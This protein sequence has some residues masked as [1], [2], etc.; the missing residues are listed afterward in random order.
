MIVYDELAKFTEAQLQFLSDRRQRVALS[1]MK[2]GNPF[3]EVGFTP[4]QLIGETAW[5]KIPNTDPRNS[6]RPVHLMDRTQIRRLRERLDEAEKSIEAM[7]EEARRLAREKAKAEHEQALA[8]KQ[9]ALSTVG[10]RVLFNG[11]PGTIITGAAARAFDPARF[12]GDG[13]TY[14]SAYVL[15][16]GGSVVYARHADLGV[17]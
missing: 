7:E 17:I 10:T 5:V 14:A 4:D 1:G 15:L 13:N 6:I 9:K 3:R 2:Y 12:G 16:D 11:K 8:K